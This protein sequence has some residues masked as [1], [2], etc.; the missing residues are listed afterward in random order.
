MTNGEFSEVEKAINYQMNNL[1]I[2]ARTDLANSSDVVYVHAYTKSDGTEVRAHY[3][4]KSD[5]VITGAAAMPEHPSKADFSGAKQNIF[6][7]A[8]NYFN[9][10]YPD[11][12]ELA[13][14]FLVKP[15]NTPKSEEYNYISPGYAKVLNEKYKLT[16]TNKEINENWSGIAYSRYSTL[17]QN[18]SKCQDLQKQVRKSFDEKTK[19][20]KTYKLDVDFNNDVN[21]NR[22]LGHATI[23]DPKIDNEGYFHGFLFDK[24]DFDLDLK[25]YTN[26]L[27]LTS[28][29]NLFWALQ[30]T[31]GRKY[32]II[33]P[34]TFKW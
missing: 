1:G 24:Y 19:Q 2:P 25:N 3:R 26:N 34:I 21:L 30:G 12:R 7:S 5:G 22:A 31:S 18:L 16:G 29:N 13:N 4:S 11:A 8:N 14:I 32:Y 6:I 15:K 33:S 9:K 20:F 27:F 17:S 28:A 10:S 23:L